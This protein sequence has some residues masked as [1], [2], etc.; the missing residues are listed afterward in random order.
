V[1][2]TSAAS[3]ASPATPQRVLRLGGASNFRDLG[4]YRTRAGRS[5]RWRRVFRSD[6]LDLLDERDWR[7]LASLGI[8]TV[9][10][11]R[12]ADEC[13]AATSRPSGPRR[14]SLPIESALGGR[15][16]ALAAAGTRVDATRMR[17]LMQEEY[18]RMLL[19]HAGRFAEFLHVLAETDGALVFHCAAGKDRTGIAAALLLATLG[20]DRATIE[21][22]YL[23]TN[24]LT[25]GL[26]TCKRRATPAASGPTP[27][28]SCGACTPATS[29]PRSMRWTRCTAGSSLFSRV[30]SACGPRCAGGCSTTSSPAVDADATPSATHVVGQGRRSSCCTAWAAT[31]VIWKPGP[32]TT[33][34][35]QASSSVQ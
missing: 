20:V 13:A 7:Q 17:T 32:L 14:V 1:N 16:A 27:S 30:R 28:R 23:L 33:L 25:P 5:V 12:A 6:R 4:G 24:V 10:D 9:V 21:Q 19:E 8:G 11:L 2:A 15:I 35:V 34:E 29:M 22:D 18:R 3:A 31:W 26:R